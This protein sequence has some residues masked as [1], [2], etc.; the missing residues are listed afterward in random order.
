MLA[1]KRILLIGVTGAGKSTGA[2]ELAQILNCPYIDFDVDI[3]WA[4]ASEAKWTVREIA[5]Q[6]HL[7]DQLLSQ[8]EWVM[9]GYS[10][11]LS[12]K[13]I[14]RTDLVIILD[15]SPLVTFGRL[16]KRSLQRL[17]DQEEI[18]NGN[19]E[20]LRQLFSTDSILL[21]WFRTVRRKRR[22]YRQA[23]DDPNF[24]VAIHLTDPRQFEALKEGWLKQLRQTREE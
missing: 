1:S 10:Q 21:W 9:A 24:P 5:Q 2:A 3:R 12:H 15:Y 7:A 8:S 20:T 22:F 23:I 4:P 6:E 11:V 19:V 18:C 13:V 14:P 17:W 16:L